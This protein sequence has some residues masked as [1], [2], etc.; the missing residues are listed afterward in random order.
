MIYP[1]RKI[2]CTPQT[3]LCMN[4][5]LVFFKMSRFETFLLQSELLPFG[6]C[7][8]SSQNQMMA[9]GERQ[10]EFQINSCSCKMVFTLLSFVK[11]EAQN[12]SVRKSLQQ[13]P[14]FALN[15]SLFLYTVWHQPAEKSL[16]DRDLSLLLLSLTEGACEAL[17]GQFSQ[18]GQALHTD[19]RLN[20]YRSSAEC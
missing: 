5:F 9:S 18:E 16:Y 7:S 4:T 17:S 6:T 8:V 1:P 19:T 14:S 2:P 11:E 15:C 10:E 13:L 20:K 12:F 3:H